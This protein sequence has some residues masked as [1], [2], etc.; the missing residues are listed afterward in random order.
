MWPSISFFGRIFLQK[1]KSM[2]IS[3]AER[4]KPFSHRI[5]EACLVPGAEAYVRVY[6]RIIEINTLSNDNLLVLQTDI[7]G[8]LKDFTIMQDLEKG[9]ISIW[10]KSDTGFFRYHISALEGCPSSLIIVA[11]KG[12][13]F[14]CEQV[15]RF[16]RLDDVRIPALPKGESY[17]VSVKGPHDHSG[18]L[19]GISPNDDS[20]LSLGSHKKQ[21]LTLMTRRNDAKEFLPLCYRLGNL[22]PPLPVL[23]EKGGTL[24]LLRKIEKL[25]EEKEHNHIVPELMRVLQ[26]AFEGLFVPSLSDVHHHGVVLPS[27]K[28]PRAAVYLV[29]RMQEIIGSLFL[30]CEAEDTVSVLPSVPPEFP[31]GRFLNIACPHSSIDLEWTKKKLRRLI[32][33]GEEDGGLNLVFRKGLKSF[34]LRGPTGLKIIK[35]DGPVKLEI[36]KDQDYELDCFTF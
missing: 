28:Q 4:L 17:L 20:R 2:K 27:F 11:E 18:A 3:I 30:R 19:I 32:I 9:V 24:S 6:P 22:L 12:I 36:V 14:A 25:I 31:C 5:G 35:V 34:R 15:E 10:G 29:K 13:S 26:I 33:H 16:I 1:E 23:H 7:V 8:P 21:D